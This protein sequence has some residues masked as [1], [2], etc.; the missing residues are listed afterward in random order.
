[1]SKLQRLLLVAVLCLTGA[2]GAVAQVPPASTTERPFAAMADIWTR[3]LD[4]IVQDAT[5][6]DLIDAEVERLRGETVAIRQAANLAASQARNEAAGLRTLLA[7]LE[8]RP[9]PAG[10]PDAKPT[11]PRPA[12]QPPEADAVKQQRDRLRSELA[13]VEA[14]IKQAELIVART[15]LLI[16][17]LGRARSDKFTRTVL[18]KGPSPL[19]PAT[20]SW[21][22]EDLGIAWRTQMT[23]WRL[24]ATSGVLTQAVHQAERRRDTITSVLALVVGWLALIW[25]RRRYGWSAAIAEPSYRDR[26]IGAALDGTGMVALPVLA[27]LLVLSWLPPLEA[28]AE[29]LRPALSTLL[30][31][32]HN[33]IFFLIVYGLSEASLTPTR[34]AWRLLPFA[35]DSAAAFCSR[36]QRL[37]GFVAIAGPV[38]AFWLLQLPGGRDDVAGLAAI[39]GLAVA[40]GLL[41]FGVPVLK[42]DAW[43]SSAATQSGTPLLIGGYGWLLGRLALGVMLIAIAIVAALGYTALTIHAGDA[44]LDSLML[45]FLAIVAHAL[46]HDVVD[47]AGAPDTPPGR[48]LRRVFGLAPDAAIHGRFV[49]VLV[50]DVA[51]LVGVAMILPVLW[52]ANPDDIVDKAHQLIAGFSIGQHRISP[53]DIG[54]ALLVFAVSMAVLRIARGALRDR[55]L[56][57]LHMQDDI[58]LSI[59]AMV[60][61]VGIVAAVLLAIAALGIDFTNLALIVGALS[62]GIGL[63]LQNLANNT[64]SGVVLLLERPIKVGDRVIVGR[65]EGIVRR[66]NVRATEIETGQRATVIVPNSEFLQSAVVNWTHADNVGRIDVALSVAHGSNPETVETILRQAAEESPYIVAVPRPLVLF[67]TISTVGLD[68]EL[69]AHVDNVANTVAAQN[70]LNRAILGRLSE[71]A[72]ALAPPPMAASTSR[73]AGTAAATSV[74]AG[75]S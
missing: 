6:P 34:P 57:S 35:A 66:I 41:A 38:S 32:A 49:L 60:N 47:A 27:I 29:V 46:V 58:R 61:Y 8:A 42:S 24:L 43:R 12:D 18:K 52:G 71:A 5:R 40:V 4:R 37:A 1:M 54:I 31:V 13:Q 17:Q 63:G 30:S 3:A 70:G 28:S 55:F 51:L 45:V 7:P 69:R 62:V 50:A 53:I 65:H 67:K 72:I 20:W 15:D 19:A 74:I 36:I 10:P 56:P 59:D 39:V 25:L 44:L 2:A 14:R 73:N 22:A 9:E 64:I 33:A 68:F 75:S 11:E 21:L 23:S 26:A 16:A 48:W